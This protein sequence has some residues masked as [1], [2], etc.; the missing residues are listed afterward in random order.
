M[1]RPERDRCCLAERGFMGRPRE[2]ASPM[3]SARI[4]PFGKE[5]ESLRRPSES[6]GRSPSNSGSLP[7]GRD[8]LMLDQFTST[9]IDVL[10]ATWKL[11]ARDIAPL[12]PVLFE[13]GMACEESGYERLETTGEAL[14]FADVYHSAALPRLTGGSCIH[15]FTSECLWLSAEAVRGRSDP[16]SAQATL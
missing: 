10:Y 3:P 5:R 12:V 4:S 16:E 6:T 7:D 11:G 14:L 8:Y 15:D 13:P 1:A 9:D 2:S